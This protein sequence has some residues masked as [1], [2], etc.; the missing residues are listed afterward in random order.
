MQTICHNGH[1]FEYLQDE[2][3]CKEKRCGETSQHMPRRFGPG[4]REEIEAR[5]KAPNPIR[6]ERQRQATYSHGYSDGFEAGILAK[7]RS[8]EGLGSGSTKF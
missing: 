6:D 5:L 4:E 2:T 1:R 7:E 8:L 3:T